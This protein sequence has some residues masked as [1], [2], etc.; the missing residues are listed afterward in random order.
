MNEKKKLPGWLIPVI[1]IA[2]VAVIGFVIYQKVYNLLFGG[3]VA[4]SIEDVYSNIYACRWQLILIGIA[5]VAAIA[6]SIAVVKLP[7]AKKIHD[8]LAIPAG[9]GAGG[10]RSGELDLPGHRVLPAQPGAG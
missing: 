5:I 1:V 10:G 6:V 3:A 4:V 8:P 9:R 7:K 2:I